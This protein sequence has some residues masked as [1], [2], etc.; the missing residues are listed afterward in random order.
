MVSIIVPVHNARE[1][2]RSSLDSVREQTYTDWEL[3]LVDDCSSDGSA[4]EIEAYA[5]EFPSLSIRLLRL[6]QNVGAAEARNRGLQVSRGRYIAF[7]DADDIWLPRKLERTLEFMN[8]HGAGFVFT[9]YEFGD[10][11]A[12]PTGK[13]VRVPLTLTYEE[14][15]SRT[16][17]FTSTV[18]V[19]SEYI[20]KKL[21]LMP[22]VPSEDT[23]T[24]WQ[25][26][27]EGHVAYG[28]NQEL[29]IYRRPQKSLSSD[30]KVAVKRIWN[31]YLREGISRPRAAILLGKWAF[32]ATV[33]RVLDDVVRSHFEAI[34]RFTVLQMSLIGLLFHTAVY[35]YVWFSSLY[36]QLNAIRISRKGYNLGV[37][38]TLYFKGHILILAIYLALLIFLSHSA[39][40]LR[41]G[42]FKPANIFSSEVTALVFTNVLTYFQ[43][44]L[45]RNWLMNPRPFL[46]LFAGQV[47]LA[48]AWTLLSD[49]IYCHVFPPREVLVVDLGGT[50]MRSE[51]LR[52]SQVMGMFETRQ[53]RF[54]L[55]RVM[56]VGIDCDL[57]EV[58]KECLRWYGSVLINGG[59]YES[60]RHLIQYC[61]RKFVRVYL[62]PSVADLLIQ[63]SDWL[64]LFDTPIL[65]LKEYTIR[66]ETRFVK[67]TFD[68]LVSLVILLV[69]SPMALIRLLKGKKLSRVVCMGRNGKP[70]TRY[71]TGL[72]NVLKGDMSL[73]GPQV[74]AYEDAKEQL[75][76][77]DRFFYRYRIK[78][79][80]TGLVRLHGTLWTSDEDRFKM[81]L[82][83]ILHYSLVNDFRILLQSVPDEKKHLRNR[84][85]KE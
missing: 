42:Y 52:L 59:D 49:Q 47:V 78:P 65:E 82:Y 54:T 2:I 9:S 36:P 1:Y 27:K 64:D 71:G 72:L 14:A 83:Y 23:A 7:L 15:L 31:L 75:E 73:V 79:G 51:E 37:G 58:K 24:W 30:K 50:D 32:R 44:S 10:E 8:R 33:R 35:G 85:R 41:T 20:D 66:W 76:R 45:M 43:L 77:D 21:L 18:L 39:G 29:V 26:L 46:L 11:R 13:V 19:D 6:E 28:L 80:I 84:R 40:G 4:E 60:R 63:G 17:I 48:G 55:S 62:A 22:K 57:E 61:Y 70:F 5:R 67:R 16:V 53:D 81:D 56:R 3:I 25:I 74:T 34:K 38:L 68:I 69:A 12:Q